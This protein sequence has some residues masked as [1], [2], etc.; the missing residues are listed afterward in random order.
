M[1]SPL[2]DAASVRFSRMIE[3]P[4]A[5]AATDGDQYT[6]AYRDVCIN[7]GIRRLM[8]KFAPQEPPG[9]VP[10]VVNEDFLRS[11]LVTEAQTLAASV[12]TLASWT[13]GVF[14]ILSAY[15]VTD[16]QIVYPASNIFR[17]ELQTGNNGYYIASSGQQRYT[18]NAASFTLFGGTATSSIRLTYIKQH[19]A[20]V[21]GASSD[22]LIPA[23][24]EDIVLDEAFKVFCEE[25]PSQENVI[26]MQLVGKNA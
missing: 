14:G 19:T 22:W 13:G 17:E 16:E 25:N 6:T 2:Y 3:D 20:M 11:Y 4:V 9:T 21:N 5:A 18:V 12:K 7:A 8:L 26:R 1:A 10:F 15:N 23:Q 24:Y